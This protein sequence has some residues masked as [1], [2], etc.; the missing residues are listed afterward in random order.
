[1]NTTEKMFTNFLALKE[2]RKRSGKSKR[3]IDMN[4]KVLSIENRIRNMA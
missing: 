2:A 4:L 1:M 3:S